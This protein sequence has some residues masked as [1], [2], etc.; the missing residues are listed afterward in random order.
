MTFTKSKLN[1]VFTVP[2]KGIAQGRQYSR[3]CFVQGKNPRRVIGAANYVTVCYASMCSKNCLYTYHQ[4]LYMCEMEII[5]CILNQRANLL[6]R[7]F[8]IFI[9]ALIL[10]RGLGSDL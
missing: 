10:S 8:R 4:W 2:I 5:E 6:T 1:L 3:E 7:P 9:F